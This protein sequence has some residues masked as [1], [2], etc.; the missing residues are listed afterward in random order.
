MIKGQGLPI[1]RQRVSAM[2]L[3]LSIVV[4]VLGV[5]LIRGV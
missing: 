2:V 3:L 4:V 1:L 5:I